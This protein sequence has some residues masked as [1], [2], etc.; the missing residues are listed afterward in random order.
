MVV[1]H[2]CSYTAEPYALEEEDLLAQREAGELDDTTLVWTAGMHDWQPLSALPALLEVRPP[3]AAAGVGSLFSRAVVSELEPADSAPPDSQMPAWELSGHGVDPFSDEIAPPPEAE[4]CD[5]PRGEG[6]EEESAAA[7]AAP[8]AFRRFGRLLEE[9]V[10]TERSYL[11]AVEQLL[12]EYRPALEPLAPTLLRAVFDELPPLQRL[13]E[14]LL[15]KLDSLARASAVQLPAA[16]EGEPQGYWPAAALAATFAPSHV[17]A[18]AHPLLRYQR[19]INQY[20]SVA[21]TLAE[22]LAVGTFSERARRVAASLGSGLQLHDLFIMPVQRLPRYVLLLEAAAAAIPAEDASHAALLRA[23]AVVRAV[24]TAVNEG[25]READSFERVREVQRRLGSALIIEHPCRRFVAEGQLLLLEGGEWVERRAVL[26]ND[27]LLLVRQEDGLG[28]RD[29]GATPRHS[30][31]TCEMLVQLSASSSV[32]DPTDAEGSKAQLLAFAAQ[33]QP[34]QDKPTSRR[35][36]SVM[37]IVGSKAASAALRRASLAIGVAGGS[38]REAPSLDAEEGSSDGEQAEREQCVVVLHLGSGRVER[39]LAAEAAAAASSRGMQAC[40]DAVSHVVLRAT[41]PQER[42]VWSERLEQT[43]AALQPERGEGSP[44]EPTGH[45][46]GVLMSGPLRKKRGSAAKAWDKRYFWLVPY[47]LMYAD[48]PPPLLA[49]YVDAKTHKSID[50]STHTLRLVRGDGEADSLELYCPYERAYHLRAESEEQTAAWAD[51]IAA[52]QARMALLVQERWDIGAANSRGRPARRAQRAAARGS[53]TA[54]STPPQLPASRL[55][56][57]QG[58]LKYGWVDRCLEPSRSK[59]CSAAKWKRQ[60][61]VLRED[62][63]LLCYSKAKDTQPAQVMFVADSDASE[64]KEVSGRPHCLKLSSKAYLDEADLLVVDLLSASEQADWHRHL[65]AVCSRA[66]PGQPSGGHT[67]RLDDHSLVALRLTLQKESRDASLGLSLRANAGQEVVSAVATGSPSEAAGL[68]AN[69]IVLAVG[70]SVALS[71]QQ[72]AAELRDAPAGA[73]NLLVGRPRMAQVAMEDI[74]SALPPTAGEGSGGDD[75]GATVLPV[76]LRQAEMMLGEVLA[77]SHEGLAACKVGLRRLGPLALL[78]AASPTHTLPLLCGQAALS[79]VRHRIKVERSVSESFLQLTADEPLVEPMMRPAL[80]AASALALPHQALASISSR[81][82]AVHLSVVAW[83]SSLK[84]STP[85][86]RQELADWLAAEVET[87]LCAAQL[88]LEATI[89]QVIA[90]SA[91]QGKELRAGYAQLSRARADLKRRHLEAEAAQAEHHK[92]TN[93]MVASRAR[94][95]TDEEPKAATFS[96]ASERLSKAAL[97][98]EAAKARTPQA[99]AAYSRLRA[100]VVVSTWKFCTLHIPALC[101]TLKSAEYERAHEVETLQW[102][103]LDAL[104]L[105]SSRLTATIESRMQS[106]AE[107]KGSLWLDATL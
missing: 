46:D 50:L 73:L 19:Y 36:F 63:L 27:M 49:T 86:Q 1:W 97:R 42:D 29:E 33:L 87:P 106:L 14:E 28:L 91:Q 90:Q 15:G 53:S 62:G 61:L 18:E 103:M 85:P 96:K 92:A 71:L 23:V 55:L 68:Q 32:V 98:L 11:A 8:A 38:G 75:P 26:L 107:Q 77:R 24:V 3:A 44:V 16:A 79:A 94:G 41:T 72:V 2:V 102:K 104:G 7:D 80:G 12:C 39:P 95:D 9:L 67:M 13:S 5:A 88:R 25:K 47:Y 82:T 4:R 65:A 70:G 74:G 40:R 64:W 58:L 21:E 22:L 48:K 52:E 31:L 54:M 17:E 20:E 35:S 100:G 78:A 83:G 30:E 99:E 105:V 69:D 81:V 6:G 66:S 43:I 84:H 45:V 57:Q 60:W 89:S 101:C 93:S 10:Q 37:R 59:A 56:R 76:R 34:T 51:A